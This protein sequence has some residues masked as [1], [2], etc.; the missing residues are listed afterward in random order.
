MLRYLVY[1]GALTSGVKN[2]L[3]LIE[4]YRFKLLKSL[5][6]LRKICLTCIIL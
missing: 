4:G 1:R 6:K 5:M 2:G 3:K